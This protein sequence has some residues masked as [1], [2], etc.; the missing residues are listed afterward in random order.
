MRGCPT[1]G[2]RGDVPNR[3][4]SVSDRCRDWGNRHRQVRPHGAHEAHHRR[5]RRVV[6]QV[7]PFQ[8][9][10]GEGLAN[11]RKRLRL[12]DRVDPQ[13]GFHIEVEV[14]HILRVARLFRHHDQHFFH[15]RVG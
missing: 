12:L 5:Q 2:R 10:N 15:H 11:G 1:G 6:A 13:V 14:Q 4:G 9:R 3:A 7:D 8:H